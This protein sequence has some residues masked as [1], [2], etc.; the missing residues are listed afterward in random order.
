MGSENK[1]KIFEQFDK[2]FEYLKVKYNLLINSD[3]ITREFEILIAG[4]SF[5]ALLIFVD[6]MTNSESINNNILAPLML[7]NSIKMTPSKQVKLNNV[8]KFNLQ[9]FLVN[10][11]ISQ[12][13]VEI[14]KDFE[15]CFGKINSGF[16]AL[17]VDTLDVAICMETKKLP[18]DLF[19]LH[20]LKLL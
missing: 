20:N 17:F 9:D 19:Q 11:L 7:K 2:N 1:A 12:N 8:Q 5:K 4:K 14:S 15:D 13:V 3:I 18:V 16:T 10:K 6:G